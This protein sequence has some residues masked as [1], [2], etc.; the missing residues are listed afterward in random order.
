MK[1]I[2][3]GV[4]QPHPEAIVPAAPQRVALSGLG[5]YVASPYKIL[6]QTTTLDVGSGKVG[7]AGAGCRQWGMGTSRHGMLQ[8]RWLLQYSEGS[9]MR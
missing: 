5:L 6:G 9:S 7:G 8:Q 3:T 2:F 1:A 4:L